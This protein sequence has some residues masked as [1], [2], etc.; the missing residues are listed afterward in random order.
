MIR[1]CTL[2][3]GWTLD[4]DCNAEQPEEPSLQLYNLPARVEIEHSILGSIQIEQ[5]EVK[6]DPTV[7]H[8]SD[9]IVDA[10]GSNPDCNSPGCEAIGRL[11]NGSAH[12]TLKIADSTIIGCVNVHAIELAENSIFM[13]DVCVG[14]RQIGCMRFCYVFPHSCTPR[15]YRC[16]PDLAEQAVDTDAER[17]RERDRV[18]PRFNS[19]RYGRPDY[20]Q[21][22]DRCAEE[23]KRGADDESEMGVFHDL[24]NPQREANLRERLEEHTP[25][26]MNVGIIFVNYETEVA[27]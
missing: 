18:R 13:G 23:I 8:I 22:A 15:R 5:D 2:V 16:Q 12:A 24:F 4:P 9:S 21:L 11:S 1:H 17:Q 25:A 19:L 26:G 20:A 14:R 10:T 27:K 7:I 6:T 3:P